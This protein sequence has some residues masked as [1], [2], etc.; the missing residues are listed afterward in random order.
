MIPRASPVTN[1][2]CHYNDDEEELNNP[3]ASPTADRCKALNNDECLLFTV[4]TLKL[5]IVTVVDAYIEKCFLFFFFKV[6]NNQQATLFSKK[7]PPP[8]WN[9]SPIRPMLVLK[10]SSRANLSTTIVMTVFLYDR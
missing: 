3:R 9:S 2:S 10:P 7:W 5:L 8:Y 1:G 6:V 4:Q